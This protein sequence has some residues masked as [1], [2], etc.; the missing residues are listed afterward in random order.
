M[1]L[2]DPR[3]GRALGAVQKGK[4][5]ALVYQYLEEYFEGRQR[6]LDSELFN[7]PEEEW[8]NIVR[9][10]I[11]VYAFLQHLAQQMKAGEGSARLL[12]PLMELHDGG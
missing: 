3:L 9:R 1:S 12:A 8:A 5:A 4:E 6:K 10:K 2:E 11:E 7:A